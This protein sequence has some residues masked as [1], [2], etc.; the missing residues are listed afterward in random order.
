MLFTAKEDGQLFN[1]DLPQ[2][3]MVDVYRLKLLSS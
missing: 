1:Q 2:K 3:W